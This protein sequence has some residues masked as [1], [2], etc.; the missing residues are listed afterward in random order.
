MEHISQMLKM[1]KQKPEAK[2][3]QINS[4]DSATKITATEPFDL[5]KLRAQVDAERAQKKINTALENAMLTPRFR[6]KSFENFVEVTPEQKAAVEAVRDFSRNHA[7]CTGLILIGN[8]GT[9]KNHVASALVKNIVEQ[10][11]T[12]LIT[13]AVKIVR[14]IKDCWIHKLKTES[15]VLKAYTEPY[16]L[17]IDELGVQFGSDTEKLYLTE[18]INDRYNW[19][20]PTVL[21]GNLTPAEVQTTIGERALDRFREGGKVVVFDWQSYRGRHE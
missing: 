7:N 5:A 21:I 1:L 17:V 14:S 10:G 18:I 16:L 19:L 2:E 8:R 12:A 11:H 3:N 4:L 20:K 15:E 13:E 6:Q 9:G